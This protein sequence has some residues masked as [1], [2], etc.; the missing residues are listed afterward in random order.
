VKEFVLNKDTLPYSKTDPRRWQDVI[1]EK[2]STLT[3]KQNRP[4]TIDLS[5]G[6]TA[7]EKDIDRNYELAGLAGRHYFYYDIDSAQHRLSLQNKNKNHRAEKLSLVYARPNDS[8]I[9]LHGL[10]ENNDSI[11]VVLERNK[12]KFLMFEGRRKQVKL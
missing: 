4:I 8:T 2:W 5:S 6:E 10:N 11:H 3:I 1:F 12:K 9:V 7:A